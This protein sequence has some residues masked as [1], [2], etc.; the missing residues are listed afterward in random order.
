MSDKNKYRK[1]LSVSP[2]FLYSA[3]KSYSF[4]EYDR[5]AINEEFHKI[6]S[7]VTAPVITAYVLY[8]LK[9]CAEKGI[10]RIYFLAR[11]GY[12]LY[13]TALILCEKMNIN[14]D[15]RYIY[16]SRASLR[17]PTYHLIGEEAFDILL[18]GGFNLSPY[19]V[20]MRAEI[21]EVERRMIY[22]ETGISFD[23]EKNIFTAEE[24]S[25]FA[26]KL[27]NN[28]RYRNIVIHKSIKAYKTAKEYFRQEGLFDDVK[29]AIVDSGWTGSMQRSLGQLLSAAAGRKIKFTGFYFGMFSEPKSEEYGEYICWYFSDKS[30][31]KYK[32]KF[33]NNL[34]ECMCS[35]NH[36][37]TI[38]YRRNCDEDRY[39]AV[40][41]EVPEINKILAEHQIKCSEIFAENLGGLFSFD[42]FNEE[43]FHT[44]TEKL[45]IK[46]MYLPSKK[47]AEAMGEFIFCDDV[48]ECYFLKLAESADKESMRETMI[49]RR[50]KRKL[51][52][53][54]RCSEFIW[55]YGTLALTDINDKFLYRISFNLWDKARFII[56]S[57]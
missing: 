12:I 8:V 56:N 46:L 11:D 33:N 22:S 55:N 26:E 28:E 17:M 13:K 34:F 9:Q 20:L 37:M 40:M 48:S 3:D 54:K 39:D 41:N 25:E 23:D 51:N 24:F 52:K 44:I 29:S 32:T 4:G 36:G 2:E 19:T 31:L 57:R 5:E 7:Y 45:L 42:K 16:C 35:A 50:I 47:E 10:E 1:Y 49:T 38:G 27:R 21:K 6:S 30:P 43:M 18:M 15:C 53:G 14:I